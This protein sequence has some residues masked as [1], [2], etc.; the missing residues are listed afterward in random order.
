VSRVDQPPERPQEL[1]DVVEM[2]TGGGLI[3]QE[4]RTWLRSGTGMV[5]RRCACAS[6]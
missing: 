4:K 5:G 2:Q 6:R 1:C 3:E